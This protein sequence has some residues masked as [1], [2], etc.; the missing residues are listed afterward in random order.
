MLLGCE[1]LIGALY[2][3][4][5]LAFIPSLSTDNDDF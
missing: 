1:F 5:L 2:L 3:L 4:L